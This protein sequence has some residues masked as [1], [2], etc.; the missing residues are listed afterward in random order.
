MRKPLRCY[1]RRHR[2]EARVGD[3]NATWY[4]CRDCGHAR[5]RRQPFV[6]SEAPAPPGQPGGGGIGM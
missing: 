3:D 6:P 1:L 2:W 4:L 5:E